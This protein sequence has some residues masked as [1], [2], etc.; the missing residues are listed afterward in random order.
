MG[1]IIRFQYRFA[2]RFVNQI[3]N[4]LAT[5]ILF[6]LYIFV[7]NNFGGFG[8]PYRSRCCLTYL[9]MIVYLWTGSEP[10][11]C[12]IHGK[13]STYWRAKNSIESSVLDNILITYHGLLSRAERKQTKTKITL[14]P[15]Q[16]NMFH[17][18]SIAIYRPARPV[19]K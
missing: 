3:A 14:R 12:S 4:R 17:R 15:S 10:G 16:H 9:Y 1:A 19:K 8:V 11:S 2:N 7:N 6:V 18:L 5:R 13:V